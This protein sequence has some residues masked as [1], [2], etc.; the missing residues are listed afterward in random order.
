MRYLKC[1]HV[2]L[3]DSIWNQ[4]LSFNLTTEGD[5]QITM[6]GQ[7]DQ[8]NVDIVINDYLPLVS[9]RLLVYKDD[10]IYTFSSYDTR[11]IPVEGLA[12]FEDHIACIEY[13]AVRGEVLATCD[14]EMVQ[15]KSAPAGETIIFSFLLY[16]VH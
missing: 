8:H 10:L 2:S 4:H 11:F 5:N 13:V 15:F 9:V 12:P 3:L 1:T 16:V 7:V 14:F 6:Y